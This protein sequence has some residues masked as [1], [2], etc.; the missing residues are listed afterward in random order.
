MSEGAEEFEEFVT[1]CEA[2]AFL[3]LGERP[4]RADVVLGD[5]R[6]RFQTDAPG[7]WPVGTLVRVT[8][9][10]LPSPGGEAASWPRPARTRIPGE[11]ATE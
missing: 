5:R 7:R 9:E 3:G 6:A 11:A 8:V 1:T 2:V 10:A 4:V